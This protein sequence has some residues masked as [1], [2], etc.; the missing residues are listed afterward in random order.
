MEKTIRMSD[1]SDISAKQIAVIRPILES[2]RTKTKPL[3][4]DLHEVFNAILYVLRKSCRWRSLS[5]DFPKWESVYYHYAKWWDHVDEESGLAFWC[6]VLKKLE[7]LDRK[8]DGRDAETTMLIIDAQS[9][10]N[11]DPAEEKVD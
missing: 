7:T 4:N 11:T 6:Q 2:A 10:K 8:R 9:V 5:H 1:P 3:E